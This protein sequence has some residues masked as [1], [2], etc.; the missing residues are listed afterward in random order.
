MNQKTPSIFTP[1]T[2][3]SPHTPTWIPG[4]YIILYIMIFAFLKNHEMITIY[5]TYVTQTPK[6]L[7]RYTYIYIILA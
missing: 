6:I 1:G 4:I 7:P 2:Y 5:V 3:T